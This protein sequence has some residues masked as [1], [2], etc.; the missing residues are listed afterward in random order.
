MPSQYD[1]FVEQALSLP[2]LISGSAERIDSGLRRMLAMEGAYS[3]T[4]VVFTGSGDSHIAAEAAARFLRQ[5]SAL[6]VHALPA[7]EA[8]R[9]LDKGHLGAM[10]RQRSLLLVAISSSGEASRTVEAAMR[11]RQA[12]ALVIG[13]TAN[14]SSRLGTAAEKVVDI[15][16]PPAKASAPGT[17]SYVAALIGAF[18]L[19]I[20]LAE[21]RLEIT[22]DF[23]NALRAEIGG[24][25]PALASATAAAL[26]AD[27]GIDWTKVEAVDCLG[28]GTSSASARFLAAKLVEAAG[29]HA[30]QQ[31]AEEFFHLNFFVDKPEQVPAVLFAPASAPARSRQRELAQTLVE[32][33]RPTVILSDDAQITGE[34]C[35]VPMPHI[36]DRF[37][38]ILHAGPAAIIAAAAAKARG[39]I[40]YR[41]HAGPWRGA[42]GAKLV[43]HS[44]LVLHGEDV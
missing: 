36:P 43:Q 15:S 41:G 22:M 27:L 4:E 24:M 23:A 26:T 25:G 29:L 20:R 39:A 37:A 19:A 13:L 3:L 21:M 18:S 9:G 11:A 40:H 44:P 16:I 38:T 14:A 31:C 5:V 34:T 8:A 10:R 33:G 35:N 1:A 42:A 2:D 30:S 7:M 17:R 32:L 28:S 12:G 6:P